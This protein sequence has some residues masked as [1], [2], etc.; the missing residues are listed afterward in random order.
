M[1]QQL[2]NQLDKW[3]TTPLSAAALSGQLELVCEMLYAGADPNV[4]GF[5][6][7]GNAAHLGLQTA[8][9]AQPAP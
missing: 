4:E 8:K 7:C 6:T 3:C 9:G 5:V 1:H 2:L